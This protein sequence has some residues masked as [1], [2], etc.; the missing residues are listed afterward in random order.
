MPSQLPAAC[1]SR[2]P[3]SFVRSLPFPIHMHLYSPSQATYP[4]SST[5]LIS[6][7]LL[8]LPNNKL[9]FHPNTSRPRQPCSMVPWIDDSLSLR[10]IRPRC[11]RRCCPGG[12]LHGTARCAD[13]FPG[14]ARR[15]RE[16]AKYWRERGSKLLEVRSIAWTICD[17]YVAD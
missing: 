3:T 11:H 2:Q 14:R 10:N 4:P 9:I 1:A 5:A 15:G 8:S 17:G 16:E 12:T 7:P 13:T 6:P